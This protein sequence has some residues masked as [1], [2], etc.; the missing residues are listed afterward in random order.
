VS[1]QKSGRIDG[2]TITLVGDLK[3]GR[4]VHSLA[5]LLALYDNVTIN[6]VSPAS[7]AMPSDLMASLSAGKT[8]L[9]QNTY[10]ALSTAILSSTDVLYVT[11]VQKERFGGNEKEYEAVK[12]AFI[13]TPAVLNTFNAKSTLSILHPLPRVNELSPDLDSDPRAAHFRQMRYGL[14]VRMALLATVLGKDRLL[15]L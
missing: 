2:L 4:T 12:D 7:L 6:Y 13:I 15:P 9:K 11:R 1:E 3:N 10:T 5:K 14:F 8:G